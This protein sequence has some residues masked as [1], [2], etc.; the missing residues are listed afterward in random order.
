MRLFAKKRRKYTI[1]SFLVTVQKPNH[2]S[3]H[4]QNTFKTRSKH[5]QNTCQTRSRSETLSGPSTHL[6]CSQTVFR[7]Q[8]LRP[9]LK[10]RRT[11]SAPNG[12]LRARASERA[13]ASASERARASGARPVRSTVGAET[14]RHLFKRMKKTSTNAKK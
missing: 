9:F 14:V 2:L 5:V 7:N 1:Y 11:Y 13:R 8:R 10:R 6:Q 12:T 3:E 4:V